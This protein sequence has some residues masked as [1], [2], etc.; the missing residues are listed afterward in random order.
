M[1]QHIDINENSEETHYCNTVRINS[2]AEEIFMD[3]GVQRP[4]KEGSSVQLTQQLAMN[5]FTA[6]RLVLSLGNHL[7]LFEEKN[8]LVDITPQNK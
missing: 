1:S 6:K 8:G 3:F 2:S 5:Y 7:R 4:A